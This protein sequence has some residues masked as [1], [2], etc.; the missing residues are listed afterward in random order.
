MMDDL[1]DA[2]ENADK[3]KYQSPSLGNELWIMEK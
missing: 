1:F 2:F 3:M